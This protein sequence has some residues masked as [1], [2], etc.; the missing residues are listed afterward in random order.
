MEQE[1]VISDLEIQPSE[2]SENGLQTP[3]NGKFTDL[4]QEEQLEFATKIATE[5]Q[6]ALYVTTKTTI[7]SLLNMLTAP[8]VDENKKAI[9]KSVIETGI[10]V[11]LDHGVNV[12]NFPMREKNIYAKYEGYLATMIAKVRD[13]GMILIAQNYK[14][15]E[16]KPHK[17]YIKGE[18]NGEINQESVE[19]VQSE[20]IDKE[21]NQNI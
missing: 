7:R 12:G 9:I 4:T 6:K 21:I 15:E 3:Q 19:G 18:E 1:Q 10:M 14:K 11:G 17:S 8:G 16:E 13:N 20:T 5:Q 2:A